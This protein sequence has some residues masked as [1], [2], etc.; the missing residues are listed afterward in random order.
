MARAY[1]TTKNDNK[2]ERLELLGSTLHAKQRTTPY[3]QQVAEGGTAAVSTGEELPGQMDCHH[4][5]GQRHKKATLNTH[6]Y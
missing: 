3:G 6:K 5:N 4:H 2:M 1:K